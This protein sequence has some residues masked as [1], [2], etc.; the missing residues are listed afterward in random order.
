MRILIKVQGS[1]L[2][3][4]VFAKRLLLPDHLARHRLADLFLDTLP[5]MLTRQ[6]VMLLWA[7]LP[8]LTQIGETFAG[9]VAASL[10]N[11][12]GLPELITHSSKEYE[13]LAIEIAK[14]PETLKAI[15]KKLT[16]NRLSTP[17]FDTKLFTRQLEAAYITMYERCQAGLAERVIDFET[18]LFGI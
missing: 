3:R 18:I 11:A 2:W 6:R 15:K 5:C 4:V 12:V 8:V 13:H 9:R 1:I 16:E 7:G 10:L 17:L 14:H